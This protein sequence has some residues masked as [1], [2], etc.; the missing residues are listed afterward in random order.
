MLQ[1]VKC[2]RYHPWDWLDLGTYTLGCNG[3]SYYSCEWR[4]IQST[5]LHGG[6]LQRKM[7]KV[8]TF[9]IDGT[10]EDTY[11]QSSSLPWAWVSSAWKWQIAFTKKEC[12]LLF[13]VELSSSTLFILLKEKWHRSSTYQMV[14]ILVSFFSK[15]KAPL[16]LISSYSNVESTGRVR[17]EKRLQRWNQIGTR[18]SSPNRESDSGDS[19]TPE[20]TIGVR[21]SRP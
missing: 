10:W 11:F 5:I 17:M 21:S 19:F 13:V 18:L 20:S 12:C 8:P 14:K 6:L 1:R 16:G 3:K 2:T 7:D 15:E 9:Q 4:L